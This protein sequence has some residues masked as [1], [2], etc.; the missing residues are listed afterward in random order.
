MTGI[1]Q[2]LLA[3]K[4]APTVLADFLVIAGGAGGAGEVA[5]GHGVGGGGGAGGYRTSAGT[6]G[7]GASAESAFNA[8]TG[9]AYTVTVGAGGTGGVARS[10]SAAVSEV[11]LYFL[12]LRQRAVVERWWCRWNVS[13]LLIPV[14]PVEEIRLLQRV[15]A[16]GTC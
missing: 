14:V 4:G 8:V 2:I 11:I 13:N 16:A 15:L 10:T 5:T 3:A 6:S 9:V 1:F 12:L 7:G